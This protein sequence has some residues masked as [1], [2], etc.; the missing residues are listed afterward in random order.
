MQVGFGQ[1][2]IIII[3]IFDLGVLIFKSSFVK[4]HNQTMIGKILNTGG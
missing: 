2:L 3:I 1:Y 4:F